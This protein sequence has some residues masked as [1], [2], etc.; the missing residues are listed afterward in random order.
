[1]L[2]I[3]A[4][5]IILALKQF[6]SLFLEFSKDC[7]FHWEWNQI[8]IIIYSWHCVFAC[9]VS[10]CFLS[11]NPVGWVA[12]GQYL[13]GECCSREVTQ[14]ADSTQLESSEFERAGKFQNIHW[15]AA[16]AC[17]LLMLPLQAFLSHCPHC[18]SPK[19]SC[20]LPKALLGC[21]LSGILPYELCET[22]GITSTQRLVQDL[23]SKTKPS[24]CRGFLLQTT[25]TLFNM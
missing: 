17:T 12:H 9:Q 4:I 8:F 16:A 3:I 18:L 15:S 20:L 5:A 19:R 23:S 7:L 1:M 2:N 21:S 24:M 22:T 10:L 6:P 14:Y 11:D 13:A 25:P